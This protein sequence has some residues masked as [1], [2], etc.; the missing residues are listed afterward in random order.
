MT[1]L[2]KQPRE[3]TVRTTGTPDINLAAE[4][5]APLFLKIHERN[6]PKRPALRVLPSQLERPHG[7]EHRRPAARAASAGEIPQSDHL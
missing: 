2:T 5:F 4:L 1:I 3:I 7:R 6:Q